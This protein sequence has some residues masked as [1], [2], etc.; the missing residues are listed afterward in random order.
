MLGSIRNLTLPLPT[1]PGRV[2][3][4]CTRELRKGEGKNGAA[5]V[6]VPARGVARVEAD[7]AT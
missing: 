2:L 1:L 6:G 3:D 7:G 4:P 5:T